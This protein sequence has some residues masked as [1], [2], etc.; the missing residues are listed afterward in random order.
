MQEICVEIAECI[1]ES[2]YLDMVVVG[3]LRVRTGTGRLEGIGQLHA[4][5]KKSA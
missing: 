2:K 4:L 3:Q 1:G 5:L